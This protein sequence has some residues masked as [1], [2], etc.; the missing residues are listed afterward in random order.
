MRL[1]SGTLRPGKILEVLENG[2]I[3]ASAPG[4]FMEEDKDNMPPIYPFFELSPQH[5]NSYST[6]V[7]G[8]EI[9]LLNQSDNPEQL[10][11]FRKDNHVENNKALFNEGGV[12]N[13]EILCNRSSNIGLAT[14]YFSD[15]SGWILRR[16]QSFLQLSPD[17][18]ILLKT[19][20]SEL[21]IY[22]DGHIELG[23]MDDDSKLVIKDSSIELGLSGMSGKIKI[24]EGNIEIGGSM[25]HSACYGDMT[26]M[27]LELIKNILASAKIA[28]AANPLTLNLVPAFA[29]AETIMPMTVESKTVKI[30]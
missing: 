26:M 2:R 21:H 17:N 4:I 14:L 11:W 5:T 25:P 19:N 8:D 27:Q 24:K 15:G 20:D 3:K 30:D 9:W 12:T 16:D 13:V 1:S 10:Y 28:A 7:V 22:D 18:S 29:L 23:M 6:P